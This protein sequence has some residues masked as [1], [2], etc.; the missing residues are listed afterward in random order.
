MLVPIVN[1]VLGGAMLIGG[2]TGKLAL[3]GTSSSPALAVAGAVVAA[4]GVYQLVR[5][6]RRR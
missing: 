5:E 1:I 6:V 4:L 3:L 2:V